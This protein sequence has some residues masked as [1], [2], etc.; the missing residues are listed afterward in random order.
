MIRKDAFGNALGESVGRS[1]VSG[2]VGR[3]NPNLF[4][5]VGSDIRSWNGVTAQQA[6]SELAPTRI[7]DGDGLIRYS[8]GRIRLPI[9]IIRRPSGSGTALL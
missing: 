7:D 5:N 8:D 1:S 6:L 3:K 9:G 2:S 4:A